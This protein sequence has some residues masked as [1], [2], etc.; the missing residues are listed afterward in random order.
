[1]KRLLSNILAMALFISLLNAC[2]G[3]TEEPLY[4]EDGIVNL[5]GPWAD[6]QGPATA[7]DAVIAEAIR[8]NMETAYQLASK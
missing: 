5:N 3:Q 2:T 1:M 6:Q 8:E 7:E 4:Y